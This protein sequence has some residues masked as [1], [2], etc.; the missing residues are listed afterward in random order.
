MI[1]LIWKIH[2]SN[3]IKLIC[4]NLHELWQVCKLHIEQ[5]SK[6]QQVELTVTVTA[7][8]NMHAG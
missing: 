8:K 3:Q 2:K 5:D 4:S 1:E 6:T 7:I